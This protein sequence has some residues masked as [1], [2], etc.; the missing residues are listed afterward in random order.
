MAALVAADSRG[1][2]PKNRLFHWLGRR[3]GFVIDAR[4]HRRPLWLADEVLK[5][6]F[7]GVQHFKNG[8]S[9]TVA[10]AL[11]LVSAGKGMRSSGANRI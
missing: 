7:D 10:T 3:D 8:Q 4:Q 1:G 9:L 6:C 5:V 11:S 2:G